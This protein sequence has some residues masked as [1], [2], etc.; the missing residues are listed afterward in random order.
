MVVATARATLRGWCE[1]GP[2]YLRGEQAGR[3]LSSRQREVLTLLAQGRSNR[4]IARVLVVSPHTVHNTVRT[5]YCRLG[6][7]GR[8]EATLA[9]VRL[10]LLSDK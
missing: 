10:G 1:V 5:I 4:E 3:P 7:C 9:A 8:V 6:V 2:T